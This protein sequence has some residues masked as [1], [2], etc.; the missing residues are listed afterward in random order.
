MLIM[1]W[2]NTSDISVS[3]R[4]IQE[5]FKGNVS[6]RVSAERKIEERHV[7]PPKKEEIHYENNTKDDI[8]VDDLLSKI[9]R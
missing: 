2:K 5:S 1:I 7:E 3:A 6:P 8:D 9:D 4:T